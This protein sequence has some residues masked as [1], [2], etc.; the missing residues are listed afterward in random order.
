MRLYI[1]NKNLSSWSMRAWLVCTAFDL[2]FEEVLVRF[3]G[4][5]LAENKFTQTMQKLNGN[6]KVPELVH[7]DRVIWDSLAICEYL[8]ELF[9]DQ[10]L[11]PED[12]RLRARARSM[13][14]EMHSSFV[15]L[16]SKCPMNITADFAHEG[17]ALWSSSAELRQDVQRIEQIWA[18]RPQP[19][20]FL[21]GNFS[22]ADAF[23]APVVCR[24]KS[25]Q[26]PVNSASVQYMNTVLAHPAVQLWIQGAMAE[27][28]I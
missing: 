23:Y 20:G 10:A 21:C 6:G 18:E 16:R 8:A 11:W 5:D 28:A 27:T 2:P 9:P 26:L 3:S 17:Q 24:F 19:E 14:A 7:D 12:R 25:Y 15:S 4:L 1:G 22:I 13:S